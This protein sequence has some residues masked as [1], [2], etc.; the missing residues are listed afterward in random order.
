M[1][2]FD[3]DLKTVDANGQAV[4]NWLEQAQSAKDGF[5]FCWL[6]IT[7][8]LLALSFVAM[9][10]Y[11]LHGAEWNES[12]DKLSKEHQAKE[13][14]YEQKILSKMEEVNN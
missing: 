10:F 5:F 2:A 6:F 11:P 4:T 14:E 1:F 12:K 3:T 13:E 8:I 7:G 9:I